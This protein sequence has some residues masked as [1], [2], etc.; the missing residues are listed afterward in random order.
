VSAVAL[1]LIIFQCFDN[2][3]NDF[4]GFFGLVSGFAEALFAERD[5]S[6]PL[7]C[8]FSLFEFLFGDGNISIKTNNTNIV[9]DG[10]PSFLWHSMENLVNFIRHLIRIKILCLAKLT[11]EHCS[12][13]HSARH[14]FIGRNCYRVQGELWNLN[15][16]L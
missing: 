9:G 8:I 10:K 14:V 3:Q 11:P 13:Q 4:W 12:Q 1:K 7:V 2:L 15:C 5:E 6:I 16:I